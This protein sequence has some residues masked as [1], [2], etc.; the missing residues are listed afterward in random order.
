MKTD[1]LTLEMIKEVDS[2]SFGEKGTLRF[3][4]SQFQKGYQK[5]LE[6][7]SYLLEN[8]YFKTKN[9]KEVQDLIR[10]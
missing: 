8:G 9:L 7:I 5:A 2:F 3:F 10:K 1:E 4:P 6:D